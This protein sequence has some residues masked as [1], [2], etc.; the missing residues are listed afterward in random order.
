MKVVTVVRIEL[1][2]EDREAIMKSHGLSGR[3][4]LETCR[5]FIHGAVEGAAHKA[6]LKARADVEGRER[7]AQEDIVWEPGME[8]PEAASA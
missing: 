7:R 6:L 3:A 4:P 1:S 2:N 5:Q 8:R